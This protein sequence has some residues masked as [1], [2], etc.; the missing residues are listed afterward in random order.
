VAFLSAADDLV[1]GD[2]NARPD[3][4]VRDRK[5]G[6]TTR[7]SL[8]ADGSQLA[9]GGSSPSISAN[10]R[11]V[12]FGTIDRSVVPGKT[13]DLPDV[14]VRDLKTGTNDRVSVSSAGEESDGT[15]YQ[16][17]L[18]ANGRFVAFGSDATNLVAGDTNGLYDIFVHDRKTG[19][20]LRVSVDSDGNQQTGSG[21]THAISANGRFVAFSSGAENLVPGDTNGQDDVFVHDLKTRSTTRVSLGA[22]GVEP[23]ASCYGPSISSNGRWVTFSSSARDLVPVSLTAFQQIYLHDAKSGATTRISGFT[24]DSEGN[25]ASQD[26]HMTPNGRFVVFSSVADNFIPGDTNAEYDVF[27]FDVR[28]G[29][30]ARTS[31][32]SD[33]AQTEGDDSYDPAISDSGR[34][35]AFSSG[36]TNLAPGDANDSS[37]VFVRTLK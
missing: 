28:R 36:A 10:G 33:G 17:V 12:A 34:F 21:E 31:V 9:E 1:P 19:E 15:A 30:L 23:D 14:V 7:V 35:V 22:T 29:V 37:D 3:V 24:P 5:R 6:T 11:Y 20:T 25:G 4:F 8:A 26:A 27:R 2:T 13:S 18:S 32:T 16:P